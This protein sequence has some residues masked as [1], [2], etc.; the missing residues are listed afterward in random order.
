MKSSILSRKPS[1][2]SPRDVPFIV[3]ELGI[4]NVCVCRLTLGHLSGHW[5]VIL[6][7]HFDHTE[8]RG[9][10]TRAIVVHPVPGDILNDEQTGWKNIEIRKM[11]QMT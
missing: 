1:V 4:E 3:R 10:L 6:I 8:K 11:V 7:T 2:S 5:L 9:A